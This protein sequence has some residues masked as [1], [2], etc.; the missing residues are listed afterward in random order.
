MKFT[1]FEKQCSDVDPFHIISIQIRI[2]PE[3]GKATRRGEKEREGER[4]RE[5]RGEKEREGREKGK[6]K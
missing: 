3:I 6:G 5:R 2:C 1:F 4:T